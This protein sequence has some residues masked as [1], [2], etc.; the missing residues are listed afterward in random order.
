MDRV[1][2]GFWM[3]FPEASHHGEPSVERHMDFFARSRTDI[4]KVMNEDTYPCEHTI[5]QASD[6][7]RLP[8]YGKT[9]P[10]IQD[11]IDIIKRVVERVDGQAPVYATIHG[12]VASASHTLL[13]YPRYDSIGRYAQYYFLRTDPDSMRVAYRRIADTLRVFCE[14]CIRAGADGI[15]YAALGGEADGF[16]AEEHAEFI[17]P[18]ECEI[19]SSVK[20]VPICN[21][22][23]A[24]KPKVELSRFTDYPCD[25]VN[26]GI[27][28]SGVSLVEGQ[29][30]FHNKA[31]IGGLDDRSPAL[32]SGDTAALTAEVEAILR[33]MEGHRFV[34]GS[35][36]TLPSDLPYEHIAEVSRICAEYAKRTH[37]PLLGRAVNATKEEVWAD[38]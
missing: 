22:L 8:V 25:A 7:K 14:E 34:L 29:R 32:L 37:I 4:F 30:L 12:L 19:L 15:Y 10:F 31:V 2:I 1:P 20:K 21:I 24:C 9:A 6:W 23:H 5:F 16:T 18:L 11:Q 26:W 35:D 28:E 17:A 36:C 33:S 27:A 38:T 3:H 13:G